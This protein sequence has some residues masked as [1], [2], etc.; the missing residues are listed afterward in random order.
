MNFF[1]LW[2]FF[3]SLTVESAIF[4]V[5]RFFFNCEGA[6]NCKNLENS[7][8]H[9]ETDYSSR[10]QLAHALE[11]IK[12]SLEQY[13][14]SYKIMVKGDR[15]KVYLNFSPIVRID[16]LNIKTK[17]GVDLSNFPLPARGEKFSTVEINKMMEDIKIFLRA[18]GY[19]DPRIN[20]KKILKNYLLSI[21]INID[22]GTL[23]KIKYVKVT[24]LGKIHHKISARFEKFKNELWNKS[25][26]DME[27]AN[28]VSLYRNEGYYL[29]RANMVEA[30]GTEGKF[31]ELVIPAVAISPGPKFGIDVRGNKSIPRS[32]IVKKL[33]R[34][35][36]DRRGEMNKFQVK[37]L[38]QDIYLERSIYHST[39]DINE[40]AF[41]DQGQPAR[42]YFIKIKEG[43]RVFIQ[44]V[45]FFGAQ[46]FTEE[47]L[48]RYF[49]SMGGAL[50]KKNILSETD[51]GNFVDTLK[52]FY[53][54]KG[55][56]FIKIV[57]PKI[58][59]DVKEKT[60]VISYRVIE[61]KQVRWG[62]FKFSS[63]PQEVKADIVR[64]IENQ[65]G[66]PVNLV[67][68]RSDIQKI[69]SSLRGKGY[70][71]AKILNQNSPKIIQYAK[72][73]SS[74]TLNAD[75]VPGEIAEFN[76]VAISGLIKTKEEVVER[77][78]FFAQ[79][80]KITPEKV[81]KLHANLSNLG[82][83]S[84]VSVAPFFTKG[85]ARKANI[86]ISVSEKKFGFLE[87]APGFRSDIG[88]KFSS[89]IGHNNLFGQN[90][91]MALRGQ[92]NQRLDFDS[93]DE[94]RQQ[95]K[96][97]RLEFKT[98]LRYDWPYFIFLPVDM[99]TL[100]SFARKRFRSF[101]T[102]IIKGTLSFNKKW[103]ELFFIFIR[104]QIENSMQF[105]ATN[106]GD[107]GSFSVG[108]I[109]SGLTFDFRNRSINPSQGGIF[110]LS[111][112]TAR[113]YLG[114]RRGASDIS[115]DEIILRN[116]LYFAGEKNMILALSFATGMQ[117]NLASGGLIPSIKTFRLNGVDQVRGFS[118][119]E[120]NHLDTANG[121]SNIDDVDVDNKAYFSNF[122]LE[123][124]YNYSDS[125]VI[126][127]FVDAGR[128][129]LNAY[130]P[131]DLRFSTGVSFK[132][133]T[134]VG[135]LNFDYGV[136]LKREYY[137]ESKK[138]KR[139]SFGRFHLTLGSF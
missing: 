116:A 137:R 106:V 111:L 10:Q 35:F 122:K 93:F 100:F 132:L 67:S 7:F 29:F 62:K 126:A 83:F 130:R 91:A 65:E 9:T 5:E 50:S 12:N 112:E 88:F 13:E 53:L 1:Y 70:F 58:R 59:E 96:D 84:S 14:M 114:S 31:D 74:A 27:L 64:D 72:D 90:H 4:R 133:V 99:S 97:R 57:G 19:N 124:R 94:R 61:G 33:K 103:R 63:I 44:A 77:E 32:D 49:F 107:A 60:A 47:K 17:H 81:R 104:Y 30:Q 78:V 135:A 87:F 37:Q 118:A 38:I 113:P 39:I 55:F 127:P 102:D 138:K 8:A 18:R 110:N 123:S 92:V 40:R 66:G 36:I 23:K 43:H 86:L 119:N 54:S 134:P 139:D 128:I 15:G 75:L 109:I 16:K 68:L 105:D 52:K 108:S 73:Y 3:F 21:E 76:E 95:S 51:A 89:A 22:E 120:I 2:L 98:S 34:S 101:D 20:V 24:S 71:F 131:L 82:I 117:K 6:I 136:K 115:Y 121:G 85:P 28:I 42:H 80:E 26:F 79:G 56:V 41:S 69:V 11:S 46:N 25:A 48:R 45:N 125:L 129:T